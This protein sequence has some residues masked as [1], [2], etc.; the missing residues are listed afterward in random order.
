M[1]RVATDGHEAGGE[2]G[3]APARQRA[4]AGLSASAAAGLLGLMAAVVVAYVATAPVT[5]ASANGAVGSAPTTEAPPITTTAPDPPAPTTTTAAPPS[6]PPVTPPATTTPTTAVEPPAPS[7][8]VVAVVGDSLAFSAALQLDPAWT[9]A[10]FTPRSA[11]APGR[12]IPVIGLDGQIS[13]GLDAIRSLKESGQ[14]ALWVVQLG[15][16]DIFFEPFDGDRYAELVTVV[17]DEI[18]PG[19]PVVWVDVWRADRPAQSQR[20]NDVLKVISAQRPQLHLADWV[21]VA[22]TEP[23]LRPDGVHLNELGVERFTRTLVDAAIVVYATSAA[24]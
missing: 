23:V 24:G 10:G 15:T 11:V 2:A 13:S 20:F 5:R 3:D 1:G 14:P 21:R 22:R 8:P 4:R 9:A 6:T 12:Q 19:V 17:L 16:N 18:G 7:G